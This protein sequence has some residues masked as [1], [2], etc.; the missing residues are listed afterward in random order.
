MST[1]MILV[2]YT[3]L[4]LIIGGRFLSLESPYEPSAAKQCNHRVQ[5]HLEGVQNSRTEKD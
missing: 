2:S 1:N 4:R 3:A 5:K